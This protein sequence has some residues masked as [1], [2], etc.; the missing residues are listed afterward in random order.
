MVA[1][2]SQL[3]CR[4][5][6]TNSA[7]LGKAEARQRRRR[8]PAHRLPGSPNTGAAAWERR[9]G[10]M[11]SAT[12]GLLTPVPNVNK[13][14]NKDGGRKEWLGQCYRG[15]RKG[16]GC[17][18]RKAELIETDLNKMEERLVK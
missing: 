11:G 12:A 15:D 4:D 1:V 8:K 10:K 13:R 2:Q 7:P 18:K 9:E 16:R 14:K 3:L 17:N 5:I 6:F